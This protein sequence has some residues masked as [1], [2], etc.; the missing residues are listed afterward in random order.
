MTRET[1]IEIEPVVDAVVGRA[2]DWMTIETPEQAQKVA[3]YL[4]EIRATRKQ[5]AD[6]FRPD[7]DRAHT[8]HKSLLEKMR[9]IDDKPARIEDGCR[10]MLEAWKRVEDEKA[11]IEQDR[12]DQEARKAAQAKALMDGD[13]R[14]ADAIDA[15]KIAVVSTA[16][17]QPEVKIR[18]VAL[19]TTWQ[20]EIV[21]K[22]ALVRAILAGKFPLEWIEFDVHAITSI[23][24]SSKGQI[25]IPG[26]IGRMVEGIRS[27]GRRA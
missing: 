25:T 12:L 22:P 24:R 1:V 7:I 21:D 4:G 20:V 2:P 26:V 17:R 5:I 18:G 3:D 11:R 8:L 27:T 9:Q 14:L 16:L 10:R 19:A 15:G 6:F 13:K 23:I